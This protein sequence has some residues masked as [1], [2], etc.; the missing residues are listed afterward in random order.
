MDAAD[1]RWGAVQ[2]TGVPLQV[3]LGPLVRWNDS[4]HRG[5]GLSKFL[6]E[7]EEDQRQLDYRSLST[8]VPA[9]FFGGGWCLSWAT[10]LDLDDTLGSG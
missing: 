7:S 6:F 2:S 9:I 1:G 3:Y 4:D 10:N 5:R 8:V